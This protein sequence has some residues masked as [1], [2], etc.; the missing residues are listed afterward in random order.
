MKGVPSRTQE[1]AARESAAKHLVGNGVELLNE[2][3]GVSFA[4]ELSDLNDSQPGRAAKEF[5]CK[6]GEDQCYGEKHRPVS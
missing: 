6:T 3:V 1:A 4:E 5:V 2:L